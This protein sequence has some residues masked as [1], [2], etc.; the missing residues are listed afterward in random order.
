MWKEHDAEIV[1]PQG[2]DPF[3]KYHVT[4]EPRT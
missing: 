3:T 2:H 1:K 4:Y